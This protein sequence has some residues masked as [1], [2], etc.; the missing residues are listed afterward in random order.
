MAITPPE[1]LAAVY[2]LA[3]RAAMVYDAVS[4]SDN[5]PLRKQ[6][7]Y[8]RWRRLCKIGWIETR[9]NDV[10]YSLKLSPR[11]VLIIVHVGLRRYEGEP[12]EQ[13]KTTRK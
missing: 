4:R 12:P 10:L 3:V 13:W 9:F 7:T 8:Q 11:T 5:G 1:T 2:E 6:D